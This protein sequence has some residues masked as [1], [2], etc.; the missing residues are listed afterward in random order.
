MK[1]STIAL[2]FG[3][4][5]QVCVVGGATPVGVEGGLVVCIGTDAL[6][7]VSGD[8]KKPG[9]VF[10][11][12]ET[13]DEK[14]AGVREKIQ[15]AECHGKVSADRF[16]G[17]ALPYIN[18][19]VNLL[20]VGEGF[21]V[22]DAELQ[23]VL[24]PYGELVANGKVTTK[25]FPENMDEWPQYL[26]GADN[27]T[28][29]Q[30]TVVGPPRHVQ[31]ISGPAWTRSHM[32][33]ATIS[34]MVSANGRL[35]TIEDTTTA[36]NP[37]L[38]AKWK[39]IARSAFN[40]VELWTLDF[41]TWEQVTVYIKRY[42]AQ[43][44]RRLVVI[45]DTVYCTPGLTAPVTAL[46]AA[47]GKVIREFKG[48]EGTQEFAYH[49]G[50]LFLVIGDRM[51]SDS[52]GDQKAKKKPGNKRQ[53]KG[54][55]KAKGQRKKKGQQGPKGTAGEPAAKPGAGEGATGEADTLF[56]R[57]GFA[58]SAY[59]PRT[60]NLEKPVCV[61]AAFDAETGKELWRTPK[62]GN[63]IGT[64]MAL[65]G[66][67]LIYQSASGVVCLDAKTGAENWV[68]KKEIPYGRGSA[69]NTLVVGD[70]AVYSEEGS[71]VFAYSLADGSDLW[72]KSIK[73]RKGY[74]ASSDL[75]IAQNALWM[76]GAGSTPGS[77]DL[78]T[79]EP[80]KTMGQTLSKPMGHDRCFRN[81]ITERFFINSKT[82]GP[83]CLDLKD[84]TEYP[85]PFTR[86]TCSMGPLPCNGLIYCGPYSCQCHLSVALHN[87]NAYYTNEDSLPTEGQVV[88]V[89]RSVRL[90]KGAAYG[91]SGKAGDA[92]WP[93][94]RQDTRRYSGSAEEVPAKEMKR[95]WKTGFP[96]KASPPVIADGKLFVAET[97]AHVLR[98]LDAASGKILWEYTAGGRIDSP[99]TFHKGLLLFGSRDG[100]MHC[101]RAKDG[102]L[103][104]RFRDLPDKLICSYGQLESAWP[105][106]G[107]VLI[108]KGIAY[109]CAGRSSYL[110]G[111]IFIYG[112]DP[113][114]GEV[115]HERQ[116]YGP[117]AENGFPDFVAEG[118]R[119]ETEVV[120]GT[121]ADVMSSDG[122][123]LYIRHQAF[124]LDLT[125]AEPGKHLLASAGF[126]EENRQHREYTL[127]QENF[128]HRKKWTTPATEYPTG[129][130]IVSDG[131]D[132]FAV[133]GMPVN[134]HS[135]FSP[136]NDGYTLKAKSKSG[137]GWSPK[138]ES[139]L[140]LTGKSMALAGDTVFIAGAPLTFEPDDLEGTYQGKHGGVLWA[141][142]VNDGS[143]V[144]EY[145]LDTL[146]AWDG[147]AA[148]YGKLY[149]VN[150]DGGVECWGAGE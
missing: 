125:D 11:C 73:A 111:G 126:L 128:N 44:Q 114:T 34:S 117:Y 45:G 1:K 79:G 85:A 136:Q 137:T 105:V 59:N 147:M 26:H 7:S 14:V 88:K 23:R 22:P 46:D 32:G 70:D 124:N 94:Y 64:T 33:A 8:W 93:T 145:K 146:P 109:F 38:P 82:G 148:A 120:L 12:L 56:S 48:T 16:D 121:T 135:S 81:F 106:H 71:Q 25:A 57:D 30:D 18:N 9:C 50:M 39:L 104:W 133:F 83:D 95:L 149:I 40:G 54:D 4:L 20:I 92:P 10:H 58:K 21:E 112:L 150:K 110:D 103:S 27:N 35:F 127:V 98:A 130:I 107:S 122:N 84:D 61:L 86:A 132:Y 13:S 115:R 2:L 77:Y 67:R 141:A 78:K 91:T 144:A 118:D 52:Y 100:W 102:E 63:Y 53:G 19:L 99:P 3:F 17:K 72:G 139:K 131:T 24:A 29:S 129:D 134:R 49:D 101:V 62:I 31:W 75:V 65:K 140:P 143:K 108:K 6:E 15:A 119:S 76:C 41:P 123:K 5:I 97:D 60:I 51:N 90:E 138:W 116:F 142:S 87:F 66:D 74:Q 55:G 37:F 80:I 28:V 47:T 36:E 43:M 113:L 96:S 69:P 89:E 68:T 42:H